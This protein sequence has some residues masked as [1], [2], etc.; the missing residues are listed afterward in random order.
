MIK[1]Y[2]LE[3]YL[4]DEV[5]NKFKEE[6]KLNAFDFF[7]IISWKS[8]RPKPAI[9]KSLMEKYDKNIEIAVQKFTEDLFKA[10]DLDKLK[11]LLE[12]DGIGLA[13]SSAVLTVLN[14][15]K[16]SIYDYRVCERLTNFKNISSS[17]NIEKKWPKYLEYVEEV[18]KIE[19][20]TFSLR[21]SDRF[22]W[23]ES[24]KKQLEKEI[25]NNFK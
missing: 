2:N 13:M 5:S 3:S 9:A 18:R 12:V 10:K 4:F 1:Y 16:Y 25:T 19:N 15:E 20:S 24:F 23:G 11:I 22:L 7:C 17:G 6:K 21:D 14:P 8:N